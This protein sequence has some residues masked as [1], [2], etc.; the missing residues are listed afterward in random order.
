MNNQSYELKLKHSQNFILFSPFVAIA[1]Y[2]ATRK[3]K[4]TVDQDVSQIHLHLSVA[5]CNVLT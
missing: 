2:S 4:E 5:G 1:K 3:G